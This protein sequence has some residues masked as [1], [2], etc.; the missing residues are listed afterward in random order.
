MTYKINISG[1]EHSPLQK[2]CM[3]ITQNRTPNV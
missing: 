3:L 2:A 1:I